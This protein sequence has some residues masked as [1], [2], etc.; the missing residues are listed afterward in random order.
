MCGRYVYEAKD[1]DLEQ[2]FDAVV[3]KIIGN[4]ARPR[5]NIAPTQYV[6]T[7]RA[8]E[9]ERAVGAMRWGLIP[10]WAKDDQIANHT[11][12]AR[13]E[14]VAEKPAFRAAFKQRRCVIPASGFYEWQRASSGK[15]A[16]KQPFYFFMKDKPV[17]G[18]AG[19]WEEWTEPQ[20]GDVIESCTIITTEANAV[21][22]PV[23]NRMPVILKPKDYEQWLDARIKDAEKLKSLLAPYPAAE[24]GSHAVSRQVNSPKS[25][26]AE[27]IN[28]LELNSK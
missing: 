11:V 10:G 15:G 9:A 22:A 16:P 25:D 5:Y 19:L 2:E 3:E 12:N 26:A 28:P 21:L 27:L 4:V 18:F 20:T 7:I 24:M 13:A 1:E 8:L 6:P 17:F 23:H 14:T